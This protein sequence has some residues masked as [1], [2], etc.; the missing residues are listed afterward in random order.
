MLLIYLLFCYC[1]KRER[2]NLEI[3]FIQ[4]LRLVT[5]IISEHPGKKLLTIKCKKYLELSMS[6]LIILMMNLYTENRNLVYNGYL[7]SD[8]KY[9]FN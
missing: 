4:L 7:L 6:K 1:H 2:A 3:L 5:Y 8:T 9:N